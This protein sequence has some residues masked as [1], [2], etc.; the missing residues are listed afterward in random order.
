[1][2]YDVA[3]ALDAGEDLKKAILKRVTEYEIYSF[4]LGHAFQI[5]VPFKSPFRKD[6]SPSFGIFQSRYYHGLLH[7]DQGDP[8]FVGD[9]F[10]F[11]SQMYSGTSYNDA[12]NL[13]HRDLYLGKLRRT[14]SYS[15]REPTEKTTKLSKLIQFEPNSSL[16]PFER[17]Y[18][19]EIGLTPEWLTF[20]KIYSAKRLF[21]D[22]QELFNWAASPGNPV[23]VYKIFDKM[24]VYRPFEKNK[25]QKWLSNTSRYDVQGWE[26][27]PELNDETTL[28]I[29]KSLKDVAVLRTLGYLAI[30]PPAESVMIPPAA[31]KL[32]SEQYG[33]KRFIL[34]YDRD[35][36][37]M[38]GARKM[39][40]RYRGEYHINFSFLHK[41]MPKDVSDFYREFGRTS[42]LRYLLY[43]L[44]YGP[45]AKLTVLSAN[46]A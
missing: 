39:F 2:L 36:G 45:N 33:I 26:Q 42:T 3:F 40:L 23:F 14:L 15:E 1:M 13:V 43:L 30:A 35:H 21:I 24:K 18:W 25:S 7:K 4:Y 8:R 27:L 10:S 34:L 22:G 19:E 11:V 37:G 5:G 29:T 32:L 44:N 9:C 16:S 38:V 46:A 28:I 31:M 12:I 20:F 17:R 41:S 6:D